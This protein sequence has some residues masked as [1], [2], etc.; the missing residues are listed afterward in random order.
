MLVCCAAASDGRSRHRAANAAL[1]GL[2]PNTRSRR[3]RRAAVR[4]CECRMDDEPELKCELTTLKRLTNPVMIPRQ[5]PELG[6]RSYVTYELGRAGLQYCLLTERNS[7]CLNIL[8]FIHSTYVLLLDITA[9]WRS[10]RGL[11]VDVNR[12][13]FAI[14]ENVNANWGWVKFT[15]ILDQIWALFQRT[16]PFRLHK[17][18]KSTLLYTA[19]LPC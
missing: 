8:F 3:Q 18:P 5:K 11:V 14:R 7:N 13:R 19:L 9:P 10:L 16:K 15:D 12:A 6:R 2:G 1:R 17:S 4:Q